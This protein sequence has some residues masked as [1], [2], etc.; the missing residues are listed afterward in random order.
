MY[1][2][3]Y[4]PSTASTAVH[5]MLIELEVPFDLVLVD[6]AAKAHKSPEFLRINPNGH[7]PNARHW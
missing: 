7:V 4:S 3:Y 6:I 2:L 5:W 1:T